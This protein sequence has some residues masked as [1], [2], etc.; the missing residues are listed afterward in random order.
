MSAGTY[1]NYLYYE[2]SGTYIKITGGTNDYRALVIPPTIVHSGI[3]YNVEEISGNAFTG[4]HNWSGFDASNSN[5][6]TIGDNAIKD[7]HGIQSIDLNNSR[8]LINIGSYAFFND[9]NASSLNL[10]DC[11]SLQYIQDRAFYACFN[12]TS[13]NFIRC[14]S[15]RSLG[16][17]CFGTTYADPGKITSINFQDSPFV[18]FSNNVFDNQQQLTS[19]IFGGNIP[20]TIPITGSNTSFTNFYAYNW[21]NFD[22]SFGGYPVTYIYSSINDLSYDL[23]DFSY[24]TITG[25]EPSGTLTI[26]PN[27]THSGLEYKVTDISSNAFINNQN[28]TSIDASNSNL[29]YIWNNAFSSCENLLSV[30]FSGSTSLQ[31]LENV[32]FKDSS[33]IN[34]IN[35]TGCYNLTTIDNDCFANIT[36]MTSYNFNDCFK[37]N[38][39]ST[40]LFDENIN[41]TSITFGSVHP[42]KFYDGGILET[43]ILLGTNIPTNAKIYVNWWSNFPSTFGTAAENS[44]SLDVIKLYNDITYNINYNIVDGSY[45][46]II[47]YNSKLET[48]LGNEYILNGALEIP[49]S[50]DGYPVKNLLPTENGELGTFQDLENITSISLP[51][52][53]ETIMGYTFRY[54]NVTSNITQINFQNLLNLKTIGWGSFSNNVNL[55]SVDLSGCISLENISAWAFNDCTNLAS[56]NLTGCNSLTTIRGQAFRNTNLQTIVIPSSV[57]L[58]ESNAFNSC[59]NLETIDL[60][61]CTSMTTIVDS[62]Y[63]NL[64]ALTSVILN[65]SLQTI[66]INAF[67][68]C[69]NLVNINLDECTNLT[70][71]GQ[72]AFDNC[73]SLQN[74]DLTNLTNLTTFSNSAFKNSGIQS[75]ILPISLNQ[76]GETTFENCLNLNSITYLGPC[77][78]DLNTNGSSVSTTPFKD[79]PTDAK[80][81]VYYQY[82]STNP[83]NSGPGPYY[84][85]EYQRA[86]TIPV[87][88]IDP[89]PPPPPPSKHCCPKPAIIDKR[90]HIYQNGQNASKLFTC[91]NGARRSRN[92]YSIP[93]S[94]AKITNICD[95]NLNLMINTNVSVSYSGYQQHIDNINRLNNSKNCQILGLKFPSRLARSS[96]F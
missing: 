90:Q 70:S 10:Q 96:L 22:T 39:I 11:I 12:I 66:S 29:K 63:K 61:N 15:L 78:S 28:I 34:Q 51:Q 80:I 57:T 41:L 92:K 56:V 45:A 20:S 30:D 86:S 14:Y 8:Q 79:L 6:I 76:Q 2:V 89:P 60:G 53:I 3:S 38:A 62:N 43:I 93:I 59:I 16:D 42:P 74:I 50:I 33:N 44:P 35:F 19:L 32:V 94:Q 67:S 18:D 71:I 48:A 65:T 69:S 52:S 36:Q 73:S 84:L 27:I 85:T 47:S 49:D 24:I 37:L 26:P 21:S 91:I 75:I 5:L 68:N 87:I 13:V 95:N 81:Y 23:I 82:S 9:Y 25:G 17:S 4:Q 64:P 55:V 88:I 72:T 58:I 1:D 83:D 46:D 77:P 54:V 40:G 31:L 7:C